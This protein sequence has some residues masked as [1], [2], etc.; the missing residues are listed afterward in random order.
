MSVDLRT[1]ATT[2]AYGVRNLRYAKGYHRGLDKGVGGGVTIGWLV[3]GTVTQITRNDAIGTWVETT[4]PGGKFVGYGHTR[5]P[6]GLRVGHAVTAG[7]SGPI[8][9]GWNDD[10]GTEWDGPHVHVWLGSRSGD[11]GRAFGTDEDPSPL[12]TATAGGGTT[13]IITKRKRRTMFLTKDAT[14]THFLITE[15]GMWVVP[16]Q[17]FAESVDRVLNYSPSRGDIQYFAGL[18]QTKP[19]VS[20]GTIDAIDPATIEKVIADAFADVNIPTP[21]ISDADVQKIAAAAGEKARALI[22]PEIAA[23]PDAVADEQAARLTD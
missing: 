22:A 10:H 3:S 5:A 21:K 23:I 16:T 2:Q 13:P 7:T 4:A 12:F 15:Q 14:T 19:W 11:M 9:Q 20:Y 8:V 18:L 1:K 17:G 6:A